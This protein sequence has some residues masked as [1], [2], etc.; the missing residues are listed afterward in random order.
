MYISGNI[1]NN[2]VVEI[3]CSFLYSWQNNDFEIHHWNLMGYHKEMSY[4]TKKLRTLLCFLF[5][6]SL[7][8]KKSFGTW[9]FSKIDVLGNVIIQK[10][11]SNY[12]VC[13]GF[14]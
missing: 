13:L 8:H 11:K 5:P 2:S 7:Y 14:L 12:L 10:L 4:I 3:K 1:S 6:I 9:Q